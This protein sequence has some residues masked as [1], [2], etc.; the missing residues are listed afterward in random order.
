M[1]ARST[2]GTKRG[3]DHLIANPMSIWYGYDAE[4]VRA[5]LRATAGTLTGV[6]VAQ[7]KADLRSSRSQGEDQ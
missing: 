4:R 5:A 2:T 1:D 6:D 7:L 3:I